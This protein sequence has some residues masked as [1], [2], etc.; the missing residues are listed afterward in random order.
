MCVYVYFNT[1]EK[2]SKVISAINDE[3]GSRNLG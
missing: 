1:L 2:N 3:G